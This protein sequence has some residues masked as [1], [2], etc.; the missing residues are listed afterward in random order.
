MQ[1]T[2]PIFFLEINN[3]DLKFIIGE[4]DENNVFKLKHLKKISTKDIEGFKRL[5]FDLIYEQVR[6]NIYSIEKEFN[7]ILKEVIVI[8]NNFDCS[9]VNCTGFKKLNGSQLEKEN[10]TYILNSLKTNIDKNEKTKTIL[11]IFN[12]KYFLDKKNIE[13]L[14]IGLFGDFYS[15][16]L[17][18][19]L[20]NE[21][22][23][24]NL[25]NVI[26]KCNL[27]ISKVISKSFV[28]GIYLI[29]QNKDIETF[30]KIEIN[31][32]DSQI[33]YFDQ[34]ALKFFQNFNFGADL[35]IKD[36]SKVLALNKETIKDILINS[37]I[38]TNNSED[39][40]IEK[41]FF[42]DQNYRKIIKKLILDIASARIEELS[43][44]IL[45]KN[46]NVQSFLNDKIPIFLMI[47]DNLKKNYLNDVYK[48][49]F[50]NKNELDMKFIENF[51]KD[52]FYKEVNKLVQFG[53]KKEA[54]PI[55]H[56]KKSIIA[57]IFNLFFN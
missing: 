38:S 26:N 29:S 7:I 46:T 49:N 41:K 18:F 3:S 50:T 13:N 10:I 12:S 19:F 44:I 11:H 21:N 57:R 56:E 8:I 47:N 1:I 42:K 39:E 34:S 48:S 23:Y 54:V 2:S 45:F 5:D 32:Y 35:I 36:I 55:V 9:L 20:I 14:P 37:S 31:D 6:K 33:M 22:D 27:K 52:E 30:F 16:E 4:N 53:W 43:E 40:F 28:E 25:R 15:H 17:S 24:K 51:D